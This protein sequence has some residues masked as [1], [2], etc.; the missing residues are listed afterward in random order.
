MRKLLLDGASNSNTRL[1]KSV[2]IQPKF[3]GE[4]WWLATLV[5]AVGTSLSY[6]LHSF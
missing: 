4:F 1:N 2:R 3:D 6:S 5:I